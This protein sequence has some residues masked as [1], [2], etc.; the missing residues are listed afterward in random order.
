MNNII[1]GI[2]NENNSLKVTQLNSFP[3]LKQYNYKYIILISEKNTIQFNFLCSICK[4]IITYNDY[5]IGK[6]QY[7][8]TVGKCENCCINLWSDFV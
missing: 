7:D 5:N 6:N 3:D 1:L 4:K 2:T 8:K